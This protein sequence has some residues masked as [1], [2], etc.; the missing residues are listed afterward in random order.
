MV[1]IHAGFFFQ[2]FDKSHLSVNFQIR[3][4]IFIYEYV[5]ICFPSVIGQFFQ[6]FKEIRD[7]FL[8]VSYF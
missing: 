8:T 5:Q 3:A 2:F 4:V 1:L 6:F 7:V